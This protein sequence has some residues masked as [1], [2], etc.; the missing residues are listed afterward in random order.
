MLA[1][2]CLLSVY[3]AES[4]RK[5]TCLAIGCLFA[6]SA[7][8]L[9]AQLA[10]CLE[11]V[12]IGSTSRLACGAL[13]QGGRDLLPVAGQYVKHVLVKPLELVAHR[14]AKILEFLSHQRG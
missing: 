1:S 6:C 3:E 5:G 4:H 11:N 14:E 13:W 10:R 7:R 8:R 2:G 12:E 9:A